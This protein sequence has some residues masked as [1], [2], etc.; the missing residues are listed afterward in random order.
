MYVWWCV[1]G[2]IN[3]QAKDVNNTNSKHPIFNLND[4][5]TCK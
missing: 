4:N 5:E 1:N 3:K 2:N